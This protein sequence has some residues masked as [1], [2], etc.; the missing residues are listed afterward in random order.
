MVGSPKPPICSITGGP[1]HDVLEGVARF[2]NELLYE[3]HSRYQ[4][5]LG[6]NRS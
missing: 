4:P 5:I 1:L 2:R 3:I 6:P